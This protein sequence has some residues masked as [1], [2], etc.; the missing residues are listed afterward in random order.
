MGS[1]AS[2]EQKSTQNF[3]QLGDLTEAKPA[4]CSHQT[5]GS[6]VVTT[7]SCQLFLPKMS[8]NYLF[9]A[10]TATRGSQRKLEARFD[11]D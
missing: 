6:H 9:L 10:M 3:A 1:V 8:N 4:I 5:Q 2:E 11:L 7:T